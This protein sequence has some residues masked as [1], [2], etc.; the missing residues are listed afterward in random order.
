MR[1]HADRTPVANDARLRR[2]LATTAPAGLPAGLTVFGSTPFDPA[3]ATTVNAPRVLLEHFDDIVR[4][5]RYSAQGPVPQAEV[6]AAFEVIRRRPY[7]P[8]IDDSSERSLGDD[9]EDLRRWV[10]ATTEALQ[11]M[12]DGSLVK[13]VLARRLRRVLKRRLSLGSLLAELEDSYPD[14]YVY[15][16]GGLVGASPELLASRAGPLVATMA[17]AGTTGYE[18][19]EVEPAA[20]L[21]SRKLRLEHTLVV[22][23]IAARLR[24]CGL[25]PV[26]DSR[27]RVASSAGLRHLRTEIAADATG[28]G[29][30]AAAIALS[31]HPT[32]AICGLPVDE[33]LRFIARHEPFRRDGYSGGFGW[34]DENGDGEWC[35]CIRCA[36]INRHS[37]LLY[38][39]SGLVLGSDPV[40]EWREA[41]AKLRLMRRALTGAGG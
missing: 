2:F 29:L 32:P 25:E 15:S 11:L 13:V 18:D 5:T 26:P 41:T 36:R 40:Q 1:L 22:N 17:L 27:A 19:A 8:S 3:V 28:N 14:H 24:A 20:V 4:V 9:N 34:T 37:A 23:H 38:G 31:L 12:R 6:C 16:H 35:V 21:G 7:R 30:S 39:G 10:M 33:A